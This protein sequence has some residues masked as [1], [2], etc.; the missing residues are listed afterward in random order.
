MTARVTR[1]SQR[2][3][4]AIETKQSSTSA[5][6]RRHRKN[7]ETSEKVES[8]NVAK[9]VNVTPPK[10]GKFT[11]EANAEYSPSSLINRLNLLEDE[12]EWRPK[13]KP[14]AKIDGARRV[15]NIGE[16]ENLYGREKELAELTEFLE[17]NV[18]L[19]TSASMYISGQPGMNI[20]WMNRFNLFVVF[21][22][23]L[24]HLR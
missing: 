15:L 22:F 2:I 13:P 9:S 23:W 18:R 6:R 24:S 10:V 1:S 4:I 3:P 19:K 7:S 14:K 21:S 11:K 17:Q 12:L 5:N 16:T 20:E 8:E